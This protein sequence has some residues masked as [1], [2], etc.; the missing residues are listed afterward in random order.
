M[1]QITLSILVKAFIQLFISYLIMFKGD[2]GRLIHSIGAM[3]QAGNSLL[4]IFS[5]IIVF[6]LYLIIV[7]LNTYKYRKQLKIMLSL[8]VFDFLLILINLFGAIATSTGLYDMPLDDAI[9]KFV[10]W[11]CGSSLVY[12]ILGLLILVPV[13]NNLKEN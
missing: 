3:L 2:A 1:K 8:Y 12:M 13:K 6:V 4:G 5:I 7:L 11:S 9:S 10:L